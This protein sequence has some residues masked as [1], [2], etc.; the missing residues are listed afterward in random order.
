MFGS[1]FMT[2]FKEMWDYRSR[3]R[4]MDKAG[5]DMAI[6]SLTCPNVFW[7]PAAISKTAEQLFGL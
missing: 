5:V 6:V 1:P 7:G 4:N 3:I 2:L